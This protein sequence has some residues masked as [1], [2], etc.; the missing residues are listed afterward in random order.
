MGTVCASR[1]S[2]LKPGGP[3]RA[4]ADTAQSRFGTVR[5]KEADPDSQADSHSVGHRQP[6]ANVSG[7]QPSNLHLARTSLDTGGRQSR[8]LQ[9]RLRALKPERLARFLLDGR[10]QCCLPLLKIT[11]CYREHSCVAESAIV[12]NR[13][14]KALLK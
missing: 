5:L 4:R 1:S 12:C 11:C 2:W 14:S 10:Q 13:Q 7:S 9:N 8:G 6:S 3:R